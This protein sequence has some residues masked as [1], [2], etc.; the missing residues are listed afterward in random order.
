MGDKF[1]DF[2]LE[3]P[4]DAKAVVNKMIDAAR[5]RKAARKAAK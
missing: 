1:T 4:Q 5:A 3:Y 2:L